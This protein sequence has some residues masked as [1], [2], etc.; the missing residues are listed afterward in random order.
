MLNA[1]EPKIINGPEVPN[2]YVRQSEENIRKLFA[3]AEKESKEK[4]E[5]SALSSYL[6]NSM[7]STN[8]VVAALVVVPALMIVL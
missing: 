6:T 2:R 8:S 5:E 7:L 3:D 4:G 1:R